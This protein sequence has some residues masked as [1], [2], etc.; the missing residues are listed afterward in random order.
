MLI[1]LYLQ[2]KNRVLLDGAHKLFSR[3]FGCYMLFSAIVSLLGSHFTVGH[4][5]NYV[6]QRL[7]TQ[8]II[9]ALHAYGHFW[10]GIYDISH[11]TPFVVAVLYISLL[12]TIYFKIRRQEEDDIQDGIVDENGVNK[13]TVVHYQKTV[14][15]NWIPFPLSQ[16]FNQIGWFR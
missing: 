11:C 4:Q 2:I 8:V 7:L 12:T 16:G 15:S 5:K 1:S 3:Q 10:L 6:L 9:V 14:K 13:R